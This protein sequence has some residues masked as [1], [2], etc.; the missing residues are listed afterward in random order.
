M[1]SGLLFILLTMVFVNPADNSQQEY[2][3][4]LRNPENRIL[5]QLQTDE[6]Y[7]S[8]LKVSDSIENL[9]AYEKNNLKG[10]GTSI[11]LL[12]NGLTE[13]E[14]CDTCTKTSQ[15]TKGNK[16]SKFF[17]RFSGFTISPNT[18][19]FIRNG[20]YYLERFIAEK[21]TEYSET[22]YKDTI[23]IKVR[24]SISELNNSEKIQLL[25]PVTKQ[26][27]SILKICFTILMLVMF[28]FV[29]IL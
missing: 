14:E 24:L 26:A 4:L 21:R 27:F 11:F 9:I 7:S 5:G 8:F 3:R 20:K 25:M 19:F 12:N 18:S 13:I 1:T 10:W 17:I 29:L 23:A 22:G 6:K 15:L 2:E 28:V 16:I